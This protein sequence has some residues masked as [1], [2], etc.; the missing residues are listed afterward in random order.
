MVPQNA[1]LPVKY[2]DVPAISPWRCKDSDVISHYILPHAM[3]CMHQHRN[4]CCEDY[5]PVE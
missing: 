1:K 2:V 5:A 4:K 3:L